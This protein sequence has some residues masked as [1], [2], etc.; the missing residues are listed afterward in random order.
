MSKR[1]YREYKKCHKQE[2]GTGIKGALD[3]SMDEE[4]VEDLECE[5]LLEGLLATSEELLGISQNQNGQLAEI[6]QILLQQEHSVQC[7]VEA[8]SRLSQ[9]VQAK[10]TE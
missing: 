5:D 9:Q 6:K 7:L 8:F 4:Y 3:A 1:N 2:S 10:P